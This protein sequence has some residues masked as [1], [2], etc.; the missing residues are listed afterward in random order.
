M[1]T[2]FISLI[3]L[4]CF[5]CKS[6]GDQQAKAENDLYDEINT[7][8]KYPEDVKKQIVERAWGSP[9]WYYPN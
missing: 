9:I 3:V 7:G 8:V 1:K 6:Q 5:A 2:K 4:F